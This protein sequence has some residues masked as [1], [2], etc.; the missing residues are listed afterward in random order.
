MIGMTGSTL[1][2]PEQ[3][4][5]ESVMIS[6]GCY[7]GFYAT[8]ELAPEALYLREFTLREKNGKYLPIDGVSPEVNDLQ[9][10]YRG[11][12]L[13]I[14]Y[15]GKIRLGNHLVPGLYVH[16]GFQKPTAFKVVL[17]FTLKEGRW[18]GCMDRSD[19]VEDQRGAFKK[20]YMSGDLR[21][22]IHEAFSLDMDLK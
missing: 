22:T 9:G 14:S 20:H 12:N 17:D 7:R 15:T 1:A 6:T 8:Y 3:F 2:T 16:M 13:S 4:G 10:S 11:L 19:E 5:M 18:V 21:Q